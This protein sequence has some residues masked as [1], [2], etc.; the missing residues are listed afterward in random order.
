[1]IEPVGGD[2]HQ[3]DRVGRDRAGRAGRVPEERD[4][5]EQ[6]ALGERA[7]EPLLAADLLADLHASL[8]HHE[9]LALGVVSLAEDDRA[10]LEGPRRYLSDLAAH[11]LL[12]SV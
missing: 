12:S 8:M 5:P 7:Q 6:L 3:G 9:G 2:D 11:E 10:R 4:V 1:M